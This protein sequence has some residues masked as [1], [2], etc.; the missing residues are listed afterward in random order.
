MSGVVV[1]TAEQLVAPLAGEHY[2]H[3]LPRKLGDDERRDRSGVRELFI[4]ELGQ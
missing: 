3:V 1:V 4:K 2:L